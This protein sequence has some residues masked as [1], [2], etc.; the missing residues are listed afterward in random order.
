MKKQDLNGVRSA[1]DLERKYRFQ[2]IEKTAAQARA[3][4][5]GMQSKLDITQYQ[6]DL[7]ELQNE[8]N[9]LIQDGL[10][11][12]EEATEQSIQQIQNELT[13]YLRTDDIITNNDIDE[14][15]EEEE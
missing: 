13:N 8:I 5:S 11:N 14:I 1:V 3:A 7:E 12:I 6:E 9:Q 10:E 15:F 2:D 4:V